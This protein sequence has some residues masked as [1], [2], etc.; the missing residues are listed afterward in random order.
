LWIIK[1]HPD[2]IP[3]L[4]TQADAIDWKDISKFLIQFTDSQVVER[5]L[6]LMVNYFH[7]TKNIGMIIV[8]Y[9]VPPEWELYRWA[10][11]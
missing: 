6:G 7:F 11:N 2:W 3:V 8:W 9:L 5:E 10:Y 1:N 4:C